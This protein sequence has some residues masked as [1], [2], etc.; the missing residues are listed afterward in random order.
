MIVIKLI[1]I[2]CFFLLVVALSFLV[3]HGII[4]FITWSVL[5]EISEYKNDRN[6]D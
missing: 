6:P 3:A 1:A 2:F 4:R 5:S